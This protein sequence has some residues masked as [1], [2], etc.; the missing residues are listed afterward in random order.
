M[1]IVLISDGYDHDAVNANVMTPVEKA[2]E[3]KIKGKF[4]IPYQLFSPYNE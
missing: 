3:N 2:S 1:Y 4:I